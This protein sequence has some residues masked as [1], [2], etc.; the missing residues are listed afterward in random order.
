MQAE[1]TTQPGY[2]KHGPAGSNRGNSRHGATIET[3][4]GGFG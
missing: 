1:L 3:P 4:K 2:E